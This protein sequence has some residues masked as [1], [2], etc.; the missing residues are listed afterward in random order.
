MNESWHSTLYVYRTK[1]R[2]AA[3]SENE[4]NFK[5]EEKYR[6]PPVYRTASAR[7]RSLRP[8]KR[9]AKEA[10]ESFRTSNWFNK[11]W[12]SKTNNFNEM[13]MSFHPSMLNLTPKLGNKIGQAKWLVGFMQYESQHATSLFLVLSLVL[14]SHHELIRQLRSLLMFSASAKANSDNAKPRQ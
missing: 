8:Q 12:S 5:L 1:F 3:I 9:N 11:D 6:T 7:C 14:C 13:P 4:T 2:G 10:E